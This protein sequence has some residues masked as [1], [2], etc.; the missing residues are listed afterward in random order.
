VTDYARRDSSAFNGLLNS[1]LM[2]LM[3]TS[4][5]LMS[6]AVTSSFLCKVPYIATNHCFI[7]IGHRRVMYQIH[8]ATDILC[9]ILHRLGLLLFNDHFNGRV[10]L[11]VGCVCVCV[12]TTTFERNDL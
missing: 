8:S 11:S 3:D 1:G 5:L 10:E 6:T 2:L 4:V 12:C 9:I 7:E